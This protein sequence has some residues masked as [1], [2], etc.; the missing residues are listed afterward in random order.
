MTIN[1]GVMDLNLNLKLVWPIQVRWLKK[2]SIT[3][4]Y[5]TKYLDFEVYLLHE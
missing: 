4:T 5:K 1:H 3:N 2:G